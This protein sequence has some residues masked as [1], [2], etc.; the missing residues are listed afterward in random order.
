[1]PREIFHN[2]IIW[3]QKNLN[4]NFANW[5]ERGRKRRRSEKNPWNLIQREIKGSNSNC[6]KRRATSSIHYSK[7]ISFEGK[8][9]EGTKLSEEKPPQ[10]M[11][12]EREQS[13]KHLETVLTRAIFTIYGQLKRGSWWISGKTQA[14]NLGR[15]V[16]IP[17]PSR[18]GLHPRRVKSDSHAHDT[19]LC[20]PSRTQSR[21]SKKNPHVIESFKTIYFPGLSFRN[22]ETED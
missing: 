2:R 7:R 1:M 22:T 8:Y 18:N 3:K 13:D 14:G 16:Y 12:R 6:F 5:N 21:I 10:I 17:S 11:S 19:Y 20:L 15:P 9:R 4:N